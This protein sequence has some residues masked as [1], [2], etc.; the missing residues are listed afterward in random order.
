MFAQLYCVTC[1]GV[2]LL[3]DGEADLHLSLH[4]S[5]FIP[6]LP[7]SLRLLTAHC[8][9]TADLHSQ[10]PLA[11][12]A[13]YTACCQVLDLAHPRQAL[14]QYSELE[15]VVLCGV[16]RMLPELTHLSLPGGTDRVLHQI[17][18]SCPSIEEL[19]L[20][21]YSPVTGPVPCIN[22]VT[23]FGVG[24]LLERCTGLRVLNLSGCRQLSS[25]FLRKLAFHRK[26][27]QPGEPRLRALFLEGCRRIDDSGLIPALPALL[28]TLEVL[29]MVG[30][31]VTEASL[32]AI[33]AHLG[34]QAQGQGRR[35]GQ[36]LGQRQGQ[37]TGREQG[38][39]GQEKSALSHNHGQ[40]QGHAVGGGPT[41]FNGRGS[42]DTG[43]VKGRRSSK[44]K[45][46]CS[47]SMGGGGVKAPVEEDQGA[48][49]S[50]V[51]R[52]TAP[53][54]VLGV[55]SKLV[56]GGSQVI[57]DLRSLPWLSV[58]KG[59]CGLVWDGFIHSPQ[60]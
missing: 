46:E 18:R 38:L 14:L 34:G 25:L 1:C 11:F 7:S 13:A 44:A 58:R 40:R 55:S 23:D 30:C 29:D 57:R 3:S 52:V 42:A 37:G 20:Q 5:S 43:C 28:E 59:S 56:Q 16:L 31:S 2:S 19:R 17:A 22:G 60:Y 8:L 24:V 6:S 53:L 10:C 15:E 32:A 35:Q 26:A 51:E 47:I 36:G 50:A 21:G 9:L 39:G 12:R 41:L 33:L 48:Q 27:G 54:R 45:E 49:S 4:Q